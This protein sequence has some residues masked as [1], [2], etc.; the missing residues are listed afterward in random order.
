MASD[1]FGDD[2][3]LHPAP[4]VTSNSLQ[5][6]FDTGQFSEHGFNPFSAL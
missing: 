1:S 5:I 6:Y 3:L 2:D 4:S